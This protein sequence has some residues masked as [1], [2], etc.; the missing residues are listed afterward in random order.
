MKV[1]VVH[2]VADKVFRRKETCSFRGVAS[3]RDSLTDKHYVT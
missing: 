2:S 1:L 3:G